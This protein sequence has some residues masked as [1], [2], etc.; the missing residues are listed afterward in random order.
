MLAVLA[1]TGCAA[2]DAGVVRPIINPA[3]GAAGLVYATPPS[4]PLRL[5]VF[6]PD[7][8]ADLRPVVLFLHGGAWSKGSR[9]EITL[10]NMAGTRTVQGLLQR[11]YAVVSADYRLSS[12]AKWPAQLSDAKA[13]VRWIRS[14]GAR[15]RLDPNRIAVWGKSAGGQLAAMVG[16]TGDDPRFAGDEGPRG[17]SS[18][19][20]A[21]LDWFGPTD[22]RALAAARDGSH[23]RDRIADL[24]G[25]LGCP[26][27]GCPPDALDAASPVHVTAAG[28]LPPFLIQHGE[29]D[30]LVP[31]AQ[32]RA[33]ADILRQ[34]GGTAE[35]VT[36][37]GVHHEFVGE[38]HPDVVQRAV[39]DFLDQHL[40]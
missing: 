36:Y 35:L 20:R 37:P 26:A 4:G 27:A 16:V 1:A 38:Q 28:G 21:V 31:V 11:G 10:P 24:T 5:D 8:A 34:R 30:Q 13:A 32:S 9:A 3:P 29:A 23:H 2:S 14:N 7:G 15:Y 19:V 22:L 33:L 25:L 6:Q 40:R 39:Y 18:A 17:V 12:V